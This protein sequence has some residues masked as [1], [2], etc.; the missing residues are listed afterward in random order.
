MG[1][2]L[3]GGEAMMGR[4][5]PTFSQLSDG[6]PSST[7]REARTRSGRPKII[8]SRREKDRKKVCKSFGR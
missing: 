1:R 4:L 3:A 7:E 5:G 8:R 2:Q 6:P